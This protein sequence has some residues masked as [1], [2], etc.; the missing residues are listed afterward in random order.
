MAE[1]VAEWLQ[2]LGLGKYAEVFADNEI[3]FTALPHL[4]EDDLKELGLP[5]GPRKVLLDALSRLSPS[6]H[7]TL[8]TVPPA[9]AAAPAD[10]ERRQL[11][12]MF[13]DLEGSTALS[14]RLDPEDLRDLMRRY[15]DAVAGAVS[16][17]A[18]YVAKYLGDGVLVYFGWP[19]A[20][21]D[22]AESGLRAGL[23]AVE[24]VAGVALAGGEPLA[25][26]VGIATGEVVIGDIVGTESA[27]TEAVIGETPNLAARLQEVAAAGQVV[28][29]QA[30]RRLIGAG[31]ELEDLGAHDLKGFA[32]PVAVWRVKGERATESR[33]AAARGRNGSIFVGREDELALLSRRWERAKAGEGQV[34]LISGEPGIGKSRLG[35][36]FNQ[37]LEDEQFIRLRYQCSPLHT[38]SAFYPFVQQLSRAGGLAPGD[39]PAQGLGKLEALFA[40]TAG[41]A[42][43]VAATMATMMSI[44][45]DNGAGAEGLSPQQQKQ[46]IFEALY[47]QLAATS[48]ERPVLAMF[49]DL[50]WIDPSSQELLEQTVGRLEDLPV[51]MLLTHRPEYEAPWVGEANVATITL[52]RLDGRQSAALVADVASAPLDQALLDEIVARSDG[53]PLFVEELTKNIVEAQSAGTPV[54]ASAIP[55]TLQDILTAR[56]DR[57]GEARDIAQIGAVA[58]RTFSYALLAASALLPEAQLVA[59]LQ[60][61]EASGLIYRRG[62]VPDAVYSFK[63]ALIQDAAYES[64]LKR[65]RRELH[66]KIAETLI[67]HFPERA[68]QEPQVMA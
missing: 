31:F 50:Q 30:T 58:G 1:D 5:M 65:R 7:A 6:E 49:E 34:A 68:E 29:D 46:R 59:G 36:S 47:A 66:G 48:R 17:H 4:S 9:R 23:D 64:L 55:A 11:T 8:G 35:E 10:A 13:C 21:E 24:A 3:G 42:A 63:H 54:A 52:N 51:L 22:Q 67:A 32:D 19:E 39:T 33:F 18:G 14:Q 60:E 43:E 38:N 26:R 37:R 2:D 40:K 53:V 62:T 15:Q 27:Q 44:P 20:H 16:R 12:V 41:D 25:A 45:L 61:L 57:L 56:L 28:I